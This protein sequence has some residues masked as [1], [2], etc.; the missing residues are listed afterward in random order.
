MTADDFYWYASVAIFIPWLLLIAAPNW[1]WTET[2]SFIAAL[3][4]LVAGAWFTYTCLRWGHEGGN[5]LSFDGLK[6]L[7]RSPEMLLAGWLN[8][9]SFCL[10][11]GVWM[12]HDA[13]DNNIGRIWQIP[14]LI[15]TL[16]AGPTGLVLYLLLRAVRTRNWKVK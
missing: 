12:V 16:L 9:L 13:I 6:N 14:C 7:F 4:L 15:L 10:L 11:V 2:L 1:R 5:V 3:I 8:Y